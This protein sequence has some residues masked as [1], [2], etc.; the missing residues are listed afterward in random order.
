MWTEPSKLQIGDMV[1]DD[2]GTPCLILKTW[3]YDSR[4]AVLK[5]G[6]KLLIESDSLQKEDINNTEKNEKC[7][8]NDIFNNIPN[9]NKDL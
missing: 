6:Y 9:I 5:N 1:L 8:D 2:N 3:Y 4:V 7:N